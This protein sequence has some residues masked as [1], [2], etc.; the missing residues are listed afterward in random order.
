MHSPRTVQPEDPSIE[1]VSDTQTK[2]A[3]LYETIYEVLRAHLIEDRLT[4]GLV[5]GEANVARAFKASRIPAAAALKRLRDEGL[6][7]D[8]GGRGYVAPTSGVAPKRL[9][10]ELSEAGLVLPAALED[11]TT[12]RNIGLRIYPEVEHAVATC[13]AYGRFMLNESALAE[14]YG[15][16]RTI[17]HE[18]LTRLARTGIIVQETNQRWYAGPLTSDAIREH[19]EMRWI[20]EPVALRQAFPKFTAK[21]LRARRDRVSGAEQGDRAPATLER[22]E[23]DLHVDTVAR[24]NNTQLLQAVRRSQLL[25]I[26]THSTFQRYQSRD[27]I[28]RMLEE[29]RTIYD[30]LLAG[31]VDG[32]AATLESHLHRS[33]RP[34]IEMM[35]RLGPLPDEMRV[36]YLTPVER[37]G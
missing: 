20:L 25:L 12:P 14:H 33:L 34:N 21:E 4:P 19:Y 23:E 7:I 3:P 16:S 32:A 10:L 24:C 1:V 2:S 5:L 31:D 35:G 8:F 29:H 30:A 15:V 6:I 13:L 26:A 17:A 37:T 36:P 27:E 11:D 28:S 22:I 9:R 18:V